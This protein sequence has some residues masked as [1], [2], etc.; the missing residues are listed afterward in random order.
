MPSSLEVP[1]IDFLGFWD[2]RSLGKAG[3]QQPGPDSWGLSRSQGGGVVLGAVGGGSER[4]R[5]QEHD[6]CAAEHGDS[7]AY[8]ETPQPVAEQC[9]PQQ[10]PLHLHTPAASAVVLE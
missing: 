7:L 4:Q 2:T 9:P 1:S 3:T 6:G 5:G 8:V 10:C